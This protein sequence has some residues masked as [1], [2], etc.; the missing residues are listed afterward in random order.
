MPSPILHGIAQKSSGENVFK[1]SSYWSSN[2]YDN[3]YFFI[4]NLL[5]FYGEI[6]FLKSLFPRLRPLCPN[7]F[8]QTQVSRVYLEIRVFS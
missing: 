2:L 5:P 7:Q 8:V 1:R 6:K 4:V 3:K